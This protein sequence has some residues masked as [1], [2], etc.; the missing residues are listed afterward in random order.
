LDESDEEQTT[1]LCR[2][3]RIPVPKSYKDYYLYSTQSDFS[4]P[5]TVKKALSNPDAIK[6]KEAMNKEFESLREN[7]T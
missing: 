6:W 2:S 5:I 7:N 4:D 3:K 1:Q